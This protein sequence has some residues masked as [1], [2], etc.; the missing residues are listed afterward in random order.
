MKVLSKIVTFMFLAVFAMS[1]SKSDPPKAVA[2]AEPTA[3]GL[4]EFFQE[5][6]LATAIADGTT[7]SPVETIINLT[8]AQSNNPKIVDFNK[9]RLEMNVDHAFQA[10]LSFVLV[11]P[12]LTE[13]TFVYRIGSSRKYVGTNKLRFSSRYTNSLPDTNIDIPA[14]DYKESKGSS[15]TTVTLL[16]I[17]SN[18]QNKNVNGTWKLKIIDNA[19]GDTGSLNSCKL[20]FESGSVL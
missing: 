6:T 1:C 17:F 8:F 11:A 13:C 9:I 14:G 10:D 15:Y 5:K 2:A 16:P 7:G 19:G 3:A 12:D 20:V 4:P 18:F